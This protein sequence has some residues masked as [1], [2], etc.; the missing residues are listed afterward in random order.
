M[1][2]ATGTA[3]PARRGRPSTGARE[4]I[5]EAAIEVLK[6]DGYAGLTIAKVAARAG[7]SKPQELPEN[8]RSRSNALESVGSQVINRRDS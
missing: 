4:R 1:T 2:D 3:T 7:E 6:A 8:A 5:L